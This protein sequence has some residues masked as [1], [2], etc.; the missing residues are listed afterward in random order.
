MIKLKKDASRRKPS[1]L[2]IQEQEAAKS[3]SVYIFV[4]PFIFDTSAYFLIHYSSLILLPYRPCIQRRERI[5]KQTTE[6]YIH[7]QMLHQ[8]PWTKAF[9]RERLKLTNWRTKRDIPLNQKRQWTGSWCC[10]ILFINWNQL[11]RA[12][13]EMILL[14]HCH[15]HIKLN[16]DLS[17][18]QENYLQGKLLARTQV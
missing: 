5:A 1:K 10:D 4:T 3:W 12:V 17:F 6:Q 9:H 13:A 2:A 7:F 16:T 8:P 18:S 14:T 11:L 15:M